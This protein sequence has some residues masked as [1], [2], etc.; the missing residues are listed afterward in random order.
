MGN[1]ISLS[2]CLFGSTPIEFMKGPYYNRH[3]AVYVYCPGSSSSLYVRSIEYE[4]SL[5]HHTHRHTHLL[6]ESKREKQLG[7]T[8]DVERRRSY[9]D[10]NAYLPRTVTTI[11][12]FLSHRH[13]H[14]KRRPM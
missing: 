5:R 11:K 7:D 10:V 14:V 9:L 3:A 13:S 2:W 8:G 1:F 12:F 4:E 6:F